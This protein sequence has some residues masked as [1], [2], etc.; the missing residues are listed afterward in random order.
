MIDLI[1]VNVYF[2]SSNKH[3]FFMV[4][5][6]VNSNNHALKMTTVFCFVLNSK[7]HLRFPVFAGKVEGTGILE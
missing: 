4:L 1:L 6:L 7:L 2:I 3:V 5:V